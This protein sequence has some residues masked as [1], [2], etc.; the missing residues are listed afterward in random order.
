MKSRSVWIIE[1]RNGVRPQNLERDCDQKIFVINNW[2]HLY[3]E[4]STRNGVMKSRSVWIIEGRNG[5]RPQNLEQWN[6]EYSNSKHF[7][8]DFNKQTSGNDKIDKLIQD[9]QI[10]DNDKWEVMEWIPFD[11][12]KDVKQIGRGGF[13]TIHHASLTSIL[14]WVSRILVHWREEST[15]TTTKLQ[16]LLIIKHIQKSTSQLFKSSKTKE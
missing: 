15:N 7:Q 13:G 10:N 11:I 8:N 16:L 9:A 5:V 12:F 3:Q 2:I 6:R 14:K 1:G 4:R